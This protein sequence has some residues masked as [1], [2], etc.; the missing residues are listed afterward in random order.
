MLN[1]MFLEQQEEKEICCCVLS[2]LVD[3]HY[4]IIRHDGRYCVV[5]LNLSMEVKYENNIKLFE[6]RDSLRITSRLISMREFN[7]FEL[8][9]YLVYF[10]MRWCKARCM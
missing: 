2:I 9:P 3:N 10:K 5:L 6:A 1:E 7:I 8:K 4:E